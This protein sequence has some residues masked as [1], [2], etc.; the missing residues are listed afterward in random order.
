MTASEVGV[1]E[2]FQ[3]EIGFIRDVAVDREA[4]RA[5]YA[6]WVKERTSAGAGRGDEREGERREESQGERAR[7]G[8][9][10]AVRSLLL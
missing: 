3:Q 8:D 5:Y 2:V 10:R 4:M 9:P 7:R 6:Q 1:S